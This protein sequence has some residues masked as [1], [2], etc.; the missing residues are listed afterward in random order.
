MLRL[1]ALLLLALTAM[2]NAQELK[3]FEA[4]SLVGEPKYKPG[5]QHLDYVNPAAPKGG[6]MRLHSIGGFDNLNPFII[7]GDPAPGVTLVYETLMDQTPDEMSTE[8][9][10][11]AS[12]V[13]VPEDLSFAIFNLRPEARFHDGKPITAEDVVWSFDTLKA[14][15]RPLYRFY[16][17]NVSKAEALGPH[18]VKFTFTG[19]R[20]RELPQIVGQLVYVMP[21]HWWATRDFESQTLEPP[22]GS[23]PYRVAHVE[24][25]R[26]IS[27][28]RVK[29]WWAKDLPLNRGRHNVD[30]IRFDMYRDT[31]VALEA[32]KAHQYDFRAEN[33]AKEWA[34]GYDFPALHEGLVVKA[35]IPHKRPTGMQAFVFNTRRPIFADRRVRQAIGYAFDFEWSNKNL[36]FEQYTRTESYFSNSDFAARGL[37]QGAEL[38]VLEKYRSKLP[39]EVFTTA[40][41]VPKT[42]GSGNNR[43]QLRAAVAL[44]QSAGWTVK[45]RQLV[46]AKGEPLQFEVLL[47]NPQFERI[48]QPFARNLERLGI[49]LRLRTV[50]SAQYQNRVRDFDYDMIVGGWAQS[51]SP[52][53]EQRDFFGSAAADRPGGRNTAGIK[54]PVIDELIETIVAAEDRERLIPAVRALDR[55]LLWGHYVIPMYHTSKDRIAYWNKFG[56]P[57][58][59]PA[60][61]VDIQSWWIEPAKDAEVRAKEEAVKR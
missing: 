44:L 3:R 10:L 53:N 35:E 52:G 20:N 23:G 32:F 7:K 33:S 46:N 30:R 43:D 15:G 29:D 13:E 50:D 27:F 59:D 34:T 61:S 48:V 36:F 19:P 24:A 51:D 17:A 39:P 18:R 28:E 45:G 12:S 1:A 37:P 4:L 25:N 41:Q 57:A 42:D 2:A 47:D 11:I 5:F 14:K 55:V 38:A 6:E 8:Y 21:K 31:T 40:Y 56:R 26:S 22:L 54:S 58:K 16:Y 60:Y 9:G 49:T